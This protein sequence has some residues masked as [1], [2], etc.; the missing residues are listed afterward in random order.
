MR[1]SILFPGLLLFSML[2]MAFQC[3]ENNDTDTMEQ[4][5]LELSQL[6]TEID[7]LIDS[8]ICGDTYHCEFIAFGSK[9]CGGPQGY[10]VYS[11]SINVEN[12]KT[13][14][15][16]YNQA[17]ADFNAKWGISSDCSVPNPPSEIICENNKCVAVF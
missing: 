3:E 10:L 13:L 16:Q 15:A 4:D 1:K 14:V 6:K 8:S 5:R 17:E 9:A 12:L 7:V 2:F 11:T